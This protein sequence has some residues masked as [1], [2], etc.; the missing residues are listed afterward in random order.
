M[1]VMKLKCAFATL[2]LVVI[3]TMAISVQSAAQ[4][5]H[6]DE[7]VE[8]SGT[9]LTLGGAD[10]RYSGPN[11]EWLGIE[12]YGPDDSIGP[13]YPS[14]LE[15]DD[16]LDTAKLMGTRV[17]RSQ[18]MGDSVGCDLCIE[19]KAGVFNP[20][21]FPINRLRD[22]GCTSSRNSPRHHASR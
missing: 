11:V 17:V 20:E 19:P 2:T 1:T 15:I 22:Q 5:R 12:A 10:Y 21:A 4:T 3:A 16:A 14:H 9:K 6:N 18:T 7:F 13:R 8:R